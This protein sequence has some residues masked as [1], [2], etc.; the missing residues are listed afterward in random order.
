[1]C[2]LNDTY[3]DNKIYISKAARKFNINAVNCKIIKYILLSYEANHCFNKF[4]KSNS[5]KL[6][7][8]SR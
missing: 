8:L 7:F 4:L 1:M 6:I 5:L 2:A 3:K